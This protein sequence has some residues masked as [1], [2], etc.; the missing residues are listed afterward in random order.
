V[1]SR[2]EVT[3]HG[4]WQGNNGVL[5]EHFLYDNGNKQKRIWHIT[6][7]DQEHYLGKANDIIGEARGQQCGA[8]IRWRYQMLIPVKNLKLKLNFDDW[9]WQ[10]NKDVMINRSYLKKFGITLAELTLIMTKQVNDSKS[11]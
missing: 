7:L 8:A 3:M 2:F 1:V 4:S 11:K 6:K 9:M 10:I 5:N